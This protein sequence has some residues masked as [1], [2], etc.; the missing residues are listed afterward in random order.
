MHT[1]DAIVAVVSALI[2]DA[3]PLAV[4][5]LAGK[6]VWAHLIIAAAICLRARW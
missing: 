2:G 1:N 4:I 3:H 6:W 5:A